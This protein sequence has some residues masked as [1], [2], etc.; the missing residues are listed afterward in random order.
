MMMKISPQHIRKEARAMLALAIP[1]VT[2]QIGMMSI[3]FVDTIMVGRLGSDQLGAVGIGAALYFAFMVFAWGTVG[4]V[5]PIVA[6]A[7]GA[8]DRDEIEKTVGQGFWLVIGLTVLGQIFMQFTGPVLR[9]IGEPEEIIPIAERFVHAI[10]FGMVASLA[11]GMLRCFTVGL[12]RTRITMVI[13]IGAALLNIAVDYVLIYGKLG[14][15]ALGAQGSG[16]ATAIVQWGM[17]AAMLLYVRR[18]GELRRYRIFALRPSFE[19]IRAMVKL[20]APIGIG[21]SLEASVFGLTSLL[22]GQIG[23]VALASHQIALNV[24]SFTFMVPLGVSMAITTRVGQFIGARDPDAASLAG[25]VGI[26]LAALFMIF[27]ALVFITIPGAIIAIYTAEPEVILYASGLLMIAG[28]FQV[29]D[30]IQVSAQGALR[31]LKDT[32]V[33]MMTNLVSYW[34]V[35]LP[36]GYLLAFVFDRGGNGLWWGLTTGLA[37]AATMHSIRFARL[38]ARSREPEPGADLSM[39]GSD[40]AG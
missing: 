6:Q 4:A 30:G 34:L 37:A 1:V 23:T 17:L 5:T 40:T 16:F 21:N 20:G 27:T 9:A 31:G 8:G 32:T 13:S 22:M 2:D 10:S 38:I 3:G 29:F 36:F 25:R 19:S 35:G 28:A 18:E 39:A 26:G 7:F 11:Y 33:P 15:P 24:A 12:G 14:I